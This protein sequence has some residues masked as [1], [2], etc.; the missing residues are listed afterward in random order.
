M[1]LLYKLKGVTFNYESYFSL[2][3]IDIQIEKSKITGILGPNGSGK[4]T[5]LN[6]LSFLDFSDSGNVFY[7][8]T[9][10][11]KHNV[12]HLRK[13]VGY[14]Q[15]NPYLFRGTVYDNLEVG[16]K[17]NYISKKQR[18]KIINKISSLLNIDH[19]LPRLANTLSGGEVRKVAIS[20][21]LVLDPD[22]LILDE[23]FSNLDKNSIID[24]ESI[25]LRLSRDKNKTIVLTTHDQLIAQRTTD[26]IYSIFNGKLFP[27]YL[28]NFYSG[29]LEIDT[30]LFNTGKVLI[31]LAGG[32]KEAKYIAIDP[33]QIVLSNKD[34]DSSMQIS[35]NGK[36]VSM[37]EENNNIKLSIDIGEKIEVLI[38]EKAFKKIN[39]SLGKNIWVS[40]KSTSIMVF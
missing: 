31:N 28:T 22:V 3:N 38:T 23:P 7:N 13:R 11:K 10:I 33:R 29:K 39:I 25:I 14:V 37:I 36:I 35:F 6:I 16:L 2:E 32:I 26:S 8:N 12:D 40:F 4:T 9:I 30:K 17:I 5:L 19:L 1:T 24:L 34:L 15:Q 21:V 27:T 20:Q 18:I